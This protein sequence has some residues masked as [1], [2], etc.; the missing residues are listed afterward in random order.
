MPDAFSNV[1]TAARKSSLASEGSSEAV[2]SNSVLKRKISTK[3]PS[4]SAGTKEN[5]NKSMTQIVREM[6]KETKLSRAIDA[7]SSL[8][9]FAEDTKDMRDPDWFS[10]GAMVYAAHPYHLARAEWATRLI[11]EHKDWIS[12]DWKNGKYTVL[13]YGC[14]SGIASQIDNRNAFKA[15]AIQ[16]YELVVVMLAID[17]FEDLTVD[18][19]FHGAQIVS[20]LQQLIRRLK[21]GGTLLII[22][23]E[24]DRSNTRAEVHGPGGLVNGHP[25]L[26]MRDVEVLHDLRFQWEATDSEKATWGSPDKADESWFMF[27]ATKEPRP[28]RIASMIP[29]TLGHEDCDGKDIEGIADNQ[30]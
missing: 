27:K 30:N 5:S 2:P 28:G 25:E 9:L 23:I 26:R 18:E 8:A 3:E 7:N 22:D 24:K 1:S 16:K 20:I 29:S 12:R 11:Q 4:D 13:D 21:S 17:C 10:M 14:G 15:L 6:V 19:C